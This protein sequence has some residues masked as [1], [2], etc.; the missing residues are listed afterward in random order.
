MASENVTPIR[1]KPTRPADCEKALALMKE[2]L[3]ILDHLV[4][5]GRVELGSCPDSTRDYLDNAIGMLK[6]DEDEE[7]AHG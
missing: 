7:V 2:A 4:E 6:P 1:R 5:A 3:D